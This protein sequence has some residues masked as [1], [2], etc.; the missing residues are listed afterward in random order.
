MPE[1]HKTRKRIA[2]KILLG[3]IILL[4]LARIALPYVVL[5]FAN[6]KLAKLDG[7][8]GHIQDIDIALYRGAY[9]MKDIYI[10]KLD[11]SGKERTDFFN[12]PRIDLSVEWKALFEKKIVGEV[13]FEQPMVK[14]TLNKTIGKKEKEDT[15]DFIEVIKDFM[16]LRINRFSV[17]RGQIHYADI[18]SDP[19]VDVPLTEVHILGKGLTNEP[20]QKNELP[21][22]INMSAKLYNGNMSMNVNLDPLNKEPTFDLD[23]KLTETD[24]L[25]LNSFF[26]AYG[27]FDLK[28]GHMS[29]YTEFAAKD[30]GFKGYV[31]PIIRDLDI[32]QFN[33]EEGNPLQ[34]TWEAFIGS[35]AEIFQNQPKGRLATKV[36]VDGKFNQPEVKTF[37]A[38]LSILKNAFIEALKPSIDHSINIHNIKKE[39]KKKF[40]L[41]TFRKKEK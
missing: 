8:Y 14:Y 32:V 28:K 21:A 34:I 18:N 13:E 1:E 24:L 39:P 12:C 17:E 6:Q 25:Y 10:D 26:A 16:P 27:N 38:I 11:P 30:Q 7:Y 35:T 3:V 15:T 19:L 33:K 22:S 31:K 2:V 20:E 5:H 4:V 37:D 23:G 36:Q 29:L 9:V 41:S 40:I